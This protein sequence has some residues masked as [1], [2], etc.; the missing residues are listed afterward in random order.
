MT[1]TGVVEISIALADDSVRLSYGD[2]IGEGMRNF[3]SQLVNM[4]ECENDDDPRKFNWQE[5]A[6]KGDKLIAKFIPDSMSPLEAAKR[7]ES[8]V[9]AE[10][11][12]PR[13]GDGW[14]LAN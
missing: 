11:Y 4:D 12:I 10:G 3:I 9:V 1:M 2:H 7:I 14:I 8:L 5:I 6:P 13:R